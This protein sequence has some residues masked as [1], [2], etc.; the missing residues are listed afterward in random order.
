MNKI[1]FLDIDGVCNDR[2]TLERRDG[3]VIGINPAMAARVK[4]I[5]K[6]TGC[7]V[8]LSS[9][10]RFGERGREVVRKHVCDFIST[11]PRSDSGFRG[12]EIASWLAS[13]P[14]VDKYAIL[15]DDADFH[16]GQTRFE[17]DFYNG[18]LTDPIADEVIKFLGKVEQ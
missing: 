7:S 10:W 13:H 17:T 5:V 1:L 12:D 6:E 3:G 4:R 15:D 2:E 18:G 8:V 11:T 9:S 16:P 14:G